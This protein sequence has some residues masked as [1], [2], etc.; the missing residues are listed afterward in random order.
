MEPTHIHYEEKFA[1]AASGYL[2]TQVQLPA[3]LEKELVLILKCNCALS[4]IGQNWPAVPGTRHKYIGI[5]SNIHSFM[6][7][8]VFTFVLCLF[9]PGRYTVVLDRTLFN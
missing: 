9:P 6:Q 7:R 8:F 5:R 2:W 4:H 3:E 1:I